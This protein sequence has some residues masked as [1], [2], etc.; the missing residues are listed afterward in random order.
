MRRVLIINSTA[1]GERGGTGITM[2]NL[3]CDYPKKCILQL[4]INVHGAV[5]DESYKTISTPVEFCRLPNMLSLIR[6]RE[7]KGQQASQV[8]IIR[9]VSQ[10]GIKNIVRDCAYGILD[11]WPVRYK[12]INAVIDAFY[13]EVIYTCGASI[14]I[15][16]T[17]LYYSNRYDIPIILHLMDDWPETLYTA[18][19]AS[20]IFR[21]IM[22]NKL[23]KVT[24]RSHQSFA[25][26]E[27]LAEK[28]E[29]RLGVRMLPL[30]NPA[31]RIVERVNAHNCE[32]VRFVYAGSFGLNRWKS[33]LDI[34]QMLDTER[35]KKHEN[36]FD[37]Y[38][39]TT[40]LTKEMEELFGQ[41]GAVLHAYV[42]HDELVRIYNESDVMV[43]A[44]SFDVNVAQYT[45]FSLSTKVPEYMGSGN[46]ILAYLPADSHASSYI[47]S[48][49]SG[50][51]ANNKNELQHII[52]E[53]L[54]DKQLRYDIAERA[55]KV[56]QLEHSKEAERNKL[57]ASVQKGIGEKRNV[58]N[59]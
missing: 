10:K 19:K 12:S 43:L 58:P 9:G 51:V 44:E 53:I 26:S 38:I 36:R 2:Q 52:G 18:S 4:R 49:K 55:L 29:K 57:Y 41:Y 50:F 21:W 27:A 8:S 6:K 45:K 3:W 24:S 54:T 42:A 59:R 30:M 22:L 16:K 20:A 17:T 32:E 14:R 56:V 31:E 40:A 34:A 5:F 25:I 1:I 39:P 13:P 33:L 15:L 11:T 23:K 47:K 46:V 28:Y 48:R 35:K 37:L 7:A